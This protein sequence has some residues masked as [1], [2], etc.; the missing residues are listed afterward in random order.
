MPW[1][2]AVSLGEPAKRTVA[3]FTPAA[4]VNQ[5]HTNPTRGPSTNGLVLE[6]PGLCPWD[7]EIAARIHLKNG[8]SVAEI[9]TLSAQWNNMEN[10]AG[11]LGT[12]FGAPIAEF[13][14]A[15]R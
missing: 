4:L 9:A 2:T 1:N 15:T 13:A 6:D 7:E 10:C 5:V 8:L 11:H 12:V 14:A 3:E